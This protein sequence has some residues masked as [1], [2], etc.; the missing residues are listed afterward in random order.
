[1]A[2]Q[3][4]TPEQYLLQTLTR[5]EL[6][7]S[8]GAGVIALAG[9]QQAFAGGHTGPRVEMSKEEQMAL[10][11]AN[12]KLIRDFC[13]DYSKLSAE[14]LDKYVHDDVI[15]QITQGM[16]EVVGREA[17]F[18]H[19]DRMLKGLD[20]TDWINLRQ[21]TIGQVVINERI[22]EFYPFPG[23]KIPRMRF[24]VA[25]YFLIEEG[26]IRIWRDFSYPGSKQL[27]EPAPKA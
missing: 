22:D 7:L 12:D 25:G 1:M 19:N 18:N 3:H 17:F 2:D 16:P 24:Q 15:Y 20:S 14:V 11:K 13:D 10:E 21:H 6:M 4:T 23:S 26:K 5:R 8:A 27:I 9:V